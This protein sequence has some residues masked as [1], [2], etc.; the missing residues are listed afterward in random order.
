MSNSF[1]PTVFI[2]FGEEKKISRDVQNK[3]LISILSNDFELY[4]N[5]NGK[6]LVKSDSPVGIS[7]THDSGVV[8]VLV[9]P[10]EPVGIDM[11]EIKEI[12]PVRVPDRFFSKKER[13]SI[14]SSKDFYK[15]W[16]KKESFVKMTGKGIAQI[17]D[18]DSFD[19][20]VIFLDLSHEISEKTGKSFSFFICS[21]THF[22]P[23]IK[24][25]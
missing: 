18:F 10:F 15:I 24:L 16:C 20:D 8:A 12:Y 4:R 14:K 13:D 6:P 11:E 21:K 9:T 7:I 2:S 19:T 23:E 22:I 1:K 5:E 17:S 25:I 3:A